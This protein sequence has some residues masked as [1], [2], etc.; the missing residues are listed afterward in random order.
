MEIG[1]PLSENIFKKII[2]NSQRLAASEFSNSDKEVLIYTGDQQLAILRITSNISDRKKES[3][4]IAYVDVE[5]A[6]D[7]ERHDFY[8]LTEKEVNAFPS[9][10][11]DEWRKKAGFH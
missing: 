10:L 2:A 9:A 6:I 1:E 5:T 8:L 4:S 11:R 7:P 3:Y